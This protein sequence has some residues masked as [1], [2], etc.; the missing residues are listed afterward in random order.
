MRPQNPEESKIFLEWL[1]SAEFAE[2]FAN[3]VPGFFL[4]THIQLM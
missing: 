4:C 3:E 1:T 2:I